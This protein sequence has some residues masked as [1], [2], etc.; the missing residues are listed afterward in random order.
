[1]ARPF[2][3]VLDGTRCV[4]DDPT[5]KSATGVYRGGMR[6][7]DLYYR[8]HAG[9]NGAPMPAAKGTCLL[10]IFGTLLTTSSRFRM[11]LTERLSRPANGSPRSH[12][13]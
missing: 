6:P 13:S 1:M 12:V 3:T 10:R 11:T 5:Q 2:E 9:I 8:I 4:P 7:I